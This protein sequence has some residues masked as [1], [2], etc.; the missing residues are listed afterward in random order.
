VAS[1]PCSPIPAFSTNGIWL[2]AL[3]DAA[4]EDQ[5]QRLKQAGK[6]DVQLSF[7]GLASTHDAFV[8]RKG[9]F[10]ALVRTARL[11]THSGLEVRSQIFANRSNAGEIADLYD[12]LLNNDLVETE[13]IS[14]PVTN[15][16]GR[17][18][19]HEDLRLDVASREQIPKRFSGQFAALSTEA[20]LAERA[21]E[22][23]DTF[24]RQVFAQLNPE[25]RICVD[26]TQDKTVL[27]SVASGSSASV[28]N[29]AETTLTDIFDSV[30]NLKAKKAGR[31]ADIGQS[32]T[33]YVGLTNRRLYQPY[34]RAKLIQFVN[35]LLDALPINGLSSS[36]WD[37][38]SDAVFEFERIDHEALG[39]RT[40]WRKH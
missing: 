2:D 14:F 5:I 24:W 15:Y 38:S 27:F 37:E 7:H 6:T 16:V 19:M 20:E 3:S 12:F 34:D 35:S 13:A 26:I 21:A 36:S 31:L 10:D 17:A 18:K 4:A 8:G 40:S 11:S 39:S 9:A 22:A 28:G 30:M 1:L 25:D 23:T 29:L 33:Q 32:A